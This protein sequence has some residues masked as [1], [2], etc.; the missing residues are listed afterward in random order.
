[1]HL[2]LLLSPETGRL[3]R[4]SCRLCI[5]NSHKVEDFVES[6]GESSLPVADLMDPVLINK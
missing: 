2:L 5:C 4:E 3:G 6:P 1:M